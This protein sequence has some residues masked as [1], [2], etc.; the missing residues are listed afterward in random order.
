M[1]IKYKKY[2]LKL[3]HKHN[4]VS[5]NKVQMVLHNSYIS[6]LCHM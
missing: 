2:F 5:N 4:L 6:E 1:D 3:Q